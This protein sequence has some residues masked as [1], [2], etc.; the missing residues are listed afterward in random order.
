MSD[1]LSTL[2]I[3]HWWHAFTGIG[4]C[5]MVASLAADVKFI[6]QKDAFLLFLA[7]FLFGVGQWINHPRVERI[8]PPFKA[9]GYNRETSLLGFILELFGCVIFAVEIYRIVFSK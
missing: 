9:I 1:P 2:K 8:I 4:A 3:D 5:G 7:F 6:P